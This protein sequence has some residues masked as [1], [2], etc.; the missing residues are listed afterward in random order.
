MKKP[1]RPYREFLTSVVTTRKFLLKTNR[2]LKSG[3]TL[4]S[5]IMRA[6]QLLMRLPSEDTVKAFLTNNYHQ[7]RELIPA[8][9]AS[10][11]RIVTLNDLING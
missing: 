7:V 4:D 11:R 10:D 3:K 9:S 2:S 1:N 5:T 6:E 8:S